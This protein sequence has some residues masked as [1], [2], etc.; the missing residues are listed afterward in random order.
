MQAQCQ[1][2]GNTDLGD[3]NGAHTDPL[4]S[5]DAES[6]RQRL[7]THLP[8]GMTMVGAYVK[9]GARKAAWGAATTLGRQAAKA[10]D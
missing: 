6:H 7:K 10:L 2:G 8:A 1:V 9:A 4:C 5:V 3:V